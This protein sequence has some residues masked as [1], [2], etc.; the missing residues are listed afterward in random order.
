MRGGV[1]VGVGFGTDE[2][3]IKV[4]VRKCHI[5]KLENEI[6]NQR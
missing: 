3:K 6:R 4:E 2:Q 5:E 1:W